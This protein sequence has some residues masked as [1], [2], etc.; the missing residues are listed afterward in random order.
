M[1]KYLRIIT[2][3]LLVCSLSVIFSA[4][5]EDPYKDYAASGL[6][7]KTRSDFSEEWEFAKWHSDTELNLLTSYSDYKDFD[8]EL[9]YTE[10]YFEHNFLLIFLRTGC[11]SDNLQFVEVLE[12]DSKLFPVL[13]RNYIGPNDPV[14]EDIIYYVFYV[15]VPGD[16][17]YTIGEVI[18]KTR[19]KNVVL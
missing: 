18:N 8:I 6:E 9:G 2:L 12:N 13:E 14:T 3:M 15:E 19:T 17:N 5:T 4:C 16:G 1:K 10:A 11:S 7:P